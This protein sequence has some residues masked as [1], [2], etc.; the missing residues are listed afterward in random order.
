MLVAL[1]E[2]VGVGSRVQDPDEAAPAADLL[3]STNSSPMFGQVLT[4]MSD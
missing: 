1:E 4:F 3:S 2:G